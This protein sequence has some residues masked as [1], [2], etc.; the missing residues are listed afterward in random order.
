LGLINPDRQEE[1]GCEGIKEEK[2][3]SLRIS[4]S[5]CK[6]HLLRLNNPVVFIRFRTSQRGKNTKIL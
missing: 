5:V 6:A 1:A 3:E 4:A 2:E